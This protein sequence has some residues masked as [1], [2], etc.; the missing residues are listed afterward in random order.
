MHTLTYTHNE[1]GTEASARNPA[2]LQI[3][4]RESNFSSGIVDHPC[5]G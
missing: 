5:N 4:Y 1:E 2:K 3:I